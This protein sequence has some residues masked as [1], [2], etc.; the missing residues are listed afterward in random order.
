M[1]E[2]T[3]VWAYLSSVVVTSVQVLHLFRDISLNEVY[4]LSLAE[5][6]ISPF[7]T[8]TL[9]PETFAFTFYAIRWDGRKLVPCSDIGSSSPYISCLS[10]SL[11]LITPLIFR[12]DSYRLYFLHSTIFFFFFVSQSLLRTRIFSFAVTYTDVTSTT[13]EEP[14]FNNRQDSR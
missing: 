7:I 1:N 3:R 10:F 5:Y 9:I 11:G 12:A 4:S 14:I 6:N 13:S 2:I 8:R